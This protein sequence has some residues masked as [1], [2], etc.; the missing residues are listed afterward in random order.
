M[1][2]RVHSFMLTISDAAPKVQSGV[3]AEIAPKTKA[4]AQ[5]T[6]M[7]PY[8]LDYLP[9]TRL[10]F[11]PHLRASRCRDQA[12]Y[13]LSDPSTAIGLGAVRDRSINSCV[14]RQ[15]NALDRSAD[16]GAYISDPSR[17]R[18]TTQHPEDTCCTEPR[19]QN[20]IS[21][22]FF[23]HP[24]RYQQSCRKTGAQHIANPL[25]TKSTT[26][27]IKQTQCFHDL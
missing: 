1:R 8:S 17:R 4:T 2:M 13:A 7:P 19:R 27:F 14:A 20:I 10:D 26:T 3:R 18:G 12:S 22:F 6:T 16:L 9:C 21:S 25:R 24:K 23:A 11:A 5:M 15:P